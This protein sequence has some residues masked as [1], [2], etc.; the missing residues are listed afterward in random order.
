MFTIYPAEKTITFQDARIAGALNFDT[1]DGLSNLAADKGWNK[2]FLTELWNDF[3]GTPEF[4][5]C[6]EQ[7]CFK[8]RG[9]GVNRIW[10]AIQRLSQPITARGNGHKPIVVAAEDSQA[11]VEP[12]A[13]AELPASGAQEAAAAPAPTETPKATTSKP[14]APKA[15]KTPKP[16]KIKMPKA[17]KT[18]RTA[19]KDSKKA[20]VIRLLQRKN[21]A[22]IEE[23]QK[24]TDGWEKHTC[25]GFMAGSLKKAGLIVTSEK[26]EGSKE[27][28]YYLP[29]AK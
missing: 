28:R 3:A 18:E 25:R 26:P 9:Y 11:P 27:R 21:G 20:E 1:L 12:P 4:N 29:A 14:K 6:R 7:K 16:A 22:S 19:R 5:D 13:P 24:A 10:C 2:E 17:P 23:I 15:P 8:N